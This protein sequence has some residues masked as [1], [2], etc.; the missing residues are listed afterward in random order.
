MSTT[1]RNA[2]I[3]NRVELKVR[4]L[5]L[6]MWIIPCKV[7]V[8]LA[9]QLYVS[10]KIDF[11]S[12]GMLIYWF[13]IQN[14]A[15]F[16]CCDFCNFSYL[17]PKKINDQH[18]GVSI[19]RNKSA[20]LFNFGISGMLLKCSVFWSWMMDPWPEEPRKKSPKLV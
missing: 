16:C 6:D 19:M 13:W 9:Y 15:S 20:R 5:C 3:A 2:V 7:I 8:Y 14:M 17:A 10:V 11:L 12:V 18:K 1:W 4:N